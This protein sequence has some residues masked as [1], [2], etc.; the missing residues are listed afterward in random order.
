MRSMRTE[1]P[2]AIRLADYRPPAFLVDEV[3]LTFDLSP[4]ATRVKARLQVRRNGDHADPLKF[5]GE[6]LKT[7]S[8]AID[9]RV[10]AEGERTIDGEYLTI[11]NAPDTF[12][13]ETEVEM[14][15]YS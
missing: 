13:L 14:V 2:Q 6:R 7:I 11:P 15:R 5:N 1:T 12:T 8:V 4:N 10:L 3:H 9:G